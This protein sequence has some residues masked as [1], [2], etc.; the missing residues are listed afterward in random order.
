MMQKL[1]Q[2]TA[3][4][5]AKLTK[6]GLMDRVNISVSRLLRRFLYDAPIAPVIKTNENE[7]LVS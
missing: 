7:N 1:K 4:P 6:I 3:G 5:K 2:K